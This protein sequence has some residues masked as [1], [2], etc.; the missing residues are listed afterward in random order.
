MLKRWMDEGYFQAPSWCHVWGQEIE[1]DFRETMAE[2]AWK[3]AILMVLYSDETRISITGS[4]LQVDLL[5]MSCFKQRVK[6][7]CLIVTILW[8]SLKYLCFTKHT[9][10]DCNHCHMKPCLTFW[11][12]VRF[13]I[14]D[15]V[16]KGHFHLGDG[17]T[18]SPLEE[19]CQK[20]WLES[21]QQFNGIN[22]NPSCYIE[23]TQQEV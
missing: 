23:K 22:S 12:P 7:F 15:R 10:F 13:W 18:Q 9:D 2:V 20:A 11:G 17:L 19:F 4:P 21:E 6:C 1:K 5:S 8:L 14:G 3:P 16:H